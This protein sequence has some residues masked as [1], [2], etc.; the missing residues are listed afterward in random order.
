[1]HIRK[2]A[3]GEQYAPCAVSWSAHS[4]GDRFFRCTQCHYVSA[5]K[6]D[7][8]QHVMSVHPELK[9]PLCPAIVDTRDSMA[10]HMVRCCL[11]MMMLMLLLMMLLIITLLFPILLYS[12]LN[13][14]DHQ[15]SHATGGGDDPRVFACEQCPY[16]TGKRRDLVIHLRTHNGKHTPTRSTYKH[17]YIHYMTRGPAVQ[18]H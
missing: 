5:E 15:S 16:R 18:V 17:T 9:C 13:I 11:M 1:M 2:H 7:L 12:N 4:H 6:Q 10:K 8:E 3:A 14:H